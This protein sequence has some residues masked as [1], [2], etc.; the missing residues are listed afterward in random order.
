MLLLPV[1]YLGFSNGAASSSSRRRRDRTV[2]RSP[3]THSTSSSEI[4]QTRSVFGNDAE[5]VIA[6]A[7]VAAAETAA[8]A[9]ALDGDAA[10]VGKVSS[11]GAGT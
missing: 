10:C 5:E 6:S 1:L 8:L 4:P 3:S 11:V 2:A 7:A 9:A